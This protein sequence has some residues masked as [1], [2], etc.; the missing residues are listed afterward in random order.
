MLAYP[1]PPPLSRLCRNRI[2]DLPSPERLRAGRSKC[3]PPDRLSPLFKKSG[4]FILRNSLQEE[5]RDE[6]SYGILSACA[7]DRGLS[8]WMNAQKVAEFFK[9][10]SIDA[11]A[12]FAIGG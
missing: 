4:F 8:P 2:T 11:P 12:D 1:Q 9:C 6:K 3:F 7:E 5:G 10:R